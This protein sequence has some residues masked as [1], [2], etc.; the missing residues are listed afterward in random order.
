MNTDNS[1]RNR[2]IIVA[3]SMA[4]VVAAGAMFSLMRAKPLPVAQETPPPA[5]VTP[6]AAALPA[7]TADA[8]PPVLT[9]APAP[10]VPATPSPPVVSAQPPRVE[11]LARAGTAKS[12]PAPEQH[13]AKAS[14]SVHSSGDRAVA[15]DQTLSS[16]PPVV[17]A[18]IPATTIAST[19]TPMYAP[20]V[21]DP[22]AALVASASSPTASP[23]I[24]QPLAVDAATA[25]P[26]TSD[27]QITTQVKS[28]I[29]ADNAGRQVDIQ[30]TTV[31][32]AVVLSG[33]M[34]TA[35]AVEHI[36]QVTERVKDVKSVDTTAVRIATT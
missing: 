25:S 35:E 33:T 24:A 36:R 34:P 26:K 5:A 9:P 10:A 22:T 18:E 19:P 4:V 2:K 3:I 31:D 17:I 30:V 14:T 11:A 32:G 20:A 13:L 28:D 29:A 6:E 27:S 1:Q 15:Y 7:A 16:T 12:K 8:A 21:S 23:A